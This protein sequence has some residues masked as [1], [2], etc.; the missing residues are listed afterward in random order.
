ME[1]H[2][3]FDIYDILIVIAYSFAYLLTLHVFLRTREK[4]TGSKKGSL[5]EILFAALWPITLPVLAWLIWK[6]KHEDDDNRLP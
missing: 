5:Q 6:H 3:S 2:P 4:T 1:G